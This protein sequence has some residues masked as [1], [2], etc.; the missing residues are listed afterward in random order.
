[1]LNDSHTHS[2]CALAHSRDEATKLLRCLW[3]KYVKPAI[4][5]EGQNPKRYRV[6]DCVSQRSEIGPLAWMAYV[7][8]KPK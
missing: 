7:E 8:A 2:A 1:M 4:L 6:T 3:V 5:A